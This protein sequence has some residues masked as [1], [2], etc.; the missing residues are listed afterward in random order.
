MNRRLSAAA[1]MNPNDRFPEPRMP[2]RTRD[3]SG[4][5]LRFEAGVPSICAF[6]GEFLAVTMGDIGLSSHA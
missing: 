4:E 2:T 1:A 6:R 5:K 3:A